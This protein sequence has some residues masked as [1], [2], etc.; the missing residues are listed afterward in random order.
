MSTADTGPTKT[1]LGPWPKLVLW[2]LVLVFGVLYLGS[3]KRNPAVD[4]QTVVPASQATLAP[5][6]LPA[7]GQAGTD[8]GGQQAPGDD[9]PG[10]DPR[11]KES[12]G[13]RRPAI[14]SRCAPPSRRPLP[15]HS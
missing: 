9:R 6:V 12:R 14:R 10:G 13:K 15:S 1:S 2:S 3:V 4:S 11:S 8:S 5:E 7:L